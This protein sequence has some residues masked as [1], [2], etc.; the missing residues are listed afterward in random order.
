[1]KKHRWILPLLLLAAACGP[2]LVSQSEF[3]MAF[4]ASNPSEYERLRFADDASD[5]Y[6]LASAEVAGDSL[7]LNV[8][9]GGGCS[10]V[11]FTL[12]LNEIILS[13]TSSLPT[14]ASV[15]VLEDPDTC[16]AEVDNTVAYPLNELP[17]GPYTLFVHNG[18]VPGQ[19]VA[20]DVPAS[21]QGN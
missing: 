11:T 12:W 16:E 21:N 1:M 8:S 13:D 2:T 5:D 9:Y 17:P 14:L 6:N 19:V 7:F 20:V 10:E 15:L 3:I 4:V 18:A